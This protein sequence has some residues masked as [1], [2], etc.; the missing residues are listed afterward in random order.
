MSSNAYMQASCMPLIHNLL[1]LD[2]EG[3][4]ICVKYF[5]ET[6]CVRSARRLRGAAW[7]TRRLHRQAAEGRVVF[8]KRCC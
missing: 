4:R 1:L 2:S 8:T 5:G 3:K 6:M 7:W